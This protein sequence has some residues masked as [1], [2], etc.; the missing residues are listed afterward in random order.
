MRLGAPRFRAPQPLSFC[1]WHPV[2]AQAICPF[3]SIKS[4]L[5]HTQSQRSSLCN[6]LGGQRSKEL[7][8]AHCTLQ[9]F[10]C[11][12]VTRLSICLSLQ[13]P[14][15]PGSASP[16][17]CPSVP[18]PHLPLPMCPLRFSSSVRQPN[19]PIP[20]CLTPSRPFSAHPSQPG[21][22]RA[23][24]PSSSIATFLRQQPRSPKPGTA[25]R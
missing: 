21:A 20:S 15:V 5:S 18:S 13:G 4:Q 14:R 3:L 24:C 9:L 1:V 25:H 17:L 16:G 12:P 10:K 19:F 7:L 11:S 23:K 6:G 2:T 22:H 8:N